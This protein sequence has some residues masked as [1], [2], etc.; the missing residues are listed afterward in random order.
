[1]DERTPSAARVAGY[2]LGCF[3]TF[4]GAAL[5]VLGVLCAL[6]SISDEP[7]L[8]SLLGWLAGILLV[9][10]IPTLGAGLYLARSA[11][12]GRDLHPGAGP[13]AYALGGVLRLLGSLSLLGLGLAFALIVPSIHASRADYSSLPFFI[14]LL[15]TF[16]LF[17]LLAGR[18]LCQ[19]KPFWVASVRRLLGI[20]LLLFAALSFVLYLTERD[21]GVAFLAVI[22]LLAGLF[23]ILPW[24]KSS[25]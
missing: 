6:F 18:K 17:G 13:A 4:L 23:V 12:P 25:A 19:G 9:S 7:I 10:G 5:T 22:L 3:L 15:A 2:G 24:R 14:A 11:Q 1:V 16:G 8:A 20:L 21:L